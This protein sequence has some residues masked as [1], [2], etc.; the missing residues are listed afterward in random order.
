MQY[1]HLTKEC[2]YF[3]H[4]WKW[5][6]ASSVEVLLTSSP[7]NDPI[8]KRWRTGTVSLSCSLLRWKEKS[9]LISPV[10]DN[11][12]RRMRHSQDFF[13]VTALS[14]GFVMNWLTFQNSPLRNVIQKVRLGSLCDVIINLYYRDSEMPIFPPFCF[15]TVNLEAIIN[16]TFLVRRSTRCPVQRQFIILINVSPLCSFIFSLFLLAELKD[17][18]VHL[19]TR[20]LNCA[21]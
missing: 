21:D 6:K 14:Y 16:H 20:G 8:N 7:L 1:F 5:V 19:Q 9:L 4:K 11:Y 15:L 2:E 17:G 12:G 3:I 10:L 18:R 13:P